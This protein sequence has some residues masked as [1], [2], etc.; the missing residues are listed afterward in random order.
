MELVISLETSSFVLEIPLP[1]TIIMDPDLKSSPYKVIRIGTDAM[2]ATRYAVVFFSVDIC[3]MASSD[4]PAKIMKIIISTAKIY[5]V[6][7]FSTLLKSA[8]IK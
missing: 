7:R 6:G 2:I 1:I 4:Q 3:A 5:K 8:R